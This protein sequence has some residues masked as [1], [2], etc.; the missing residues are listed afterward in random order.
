MQKNKKKV[1]VVGAGPSGLVTVKE[2]LNQNFEVVCYE[3]QESFGGVFRS[4]NQGGNAYDSL[5]LTI[6]NFFMA[7][8]DF[9]PKPGEERRYWKVSEYIS[10]LN[11]YIEKHKLNKCIYYSHEV[12]EAS[13]QGKKVIIKVNNQNRIKTQY[14]DNL[15][16]CSGCN[17][18]P[19]IPEFKNQNLFK[20]KIIHSSEYK[21][22]S[23]FKSKNIIC[24]G[25]GESGADITHEISQ[26][27][28]C[29]VLVRDYP[30]I[31]PKWIKGYTNDAYT[32]Y[33]FYKM[34]KSGIDFFMKIK[35]KL[36][37]YFN[38]MTPGERLVQEWVC[39]RD[40]FTSKVLIKNDI[41]IDDII[42]G[43]LEI[44]KDEVKLLTEDTVVTKENKKLKA[45]V[46][47]CNNGYKTQFDRFS[48]GSDFENPR[49][50]F[51]NMIHPMYGLRVV[52]IGWARPTQG[53]FP[54]CSEMQA[55][56]LSLLLAG[57]KNI[58][59][60][61]LMSETILKD[62]YYYENLF[63]E[64]KEI[65]SLVNYHDYIK[66]MSKL[67]GCKPNFY[68]IKNFS[69]LRKFV[70]GSQLASFYRLSDSDDNDEIR[71]VIR[72]L[73]IAYSNRRLLFILLIIGFYKPI[74]FFFE[75]KNNKNHRRI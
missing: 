23:E 28:N 71:R 30:N 19:S 70:F 10:Y 16:I 52:L 69:L 26:V 59:S 18:V 61:S 62:T 32:S 44:L 60:K 74:A 31:V 46:I 72:K 36:Y 17:F 2:L 65:T 24:I 50:L 63:S 34:G 7:Y 1:C 33:I 41:F 14:F 51:K 12:I 45:D 68:N 13:M 25:L 35:A 3:S 8:S 75:K 4:I 37:L 20:G 39:A 21:N 54:T 22:S 56:Y 64:S 43:K 42:N 47:I 27:A 40:S 6:S 38:K 15:V 5:E 53:G 29:K 58:P 66:E 49:N 11:K 9:M 67:I 48:F 55:R 57:K 73:P